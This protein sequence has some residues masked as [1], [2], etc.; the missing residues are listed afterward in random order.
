MWLLR[1]LIRRGERQ[2]GIVIPTR[3]F[4]I[5]HPSL[6]ITRSAIQYG[7]R[8]T[9]SF[10]KYVAVGVFTP[11]MIARLLGKTPDDL[12]VRTIG[13]GHLV[14]IAVS[15]PLTRK[16]RK[17]QGI[18]LASTRAQATADLEAAQRPS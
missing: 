14:S 15:K 8:G 2:A 1:Y 6:A 7:I 13:M 16:E 12:G 17:R 11:R 10:W 9:S 5:L 4:Y 3:L 18:S